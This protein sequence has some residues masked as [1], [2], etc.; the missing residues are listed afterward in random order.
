MRCARASFVRL[1]WEYNRGFF[2]SEGVSILVA[3]TVFQSEQDQPREAGAPQAYPNLM[4]FN[5]VDK[6]GHVAAWEQPQL[7]SD[8]IRAAFKSLRRRRHHD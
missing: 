8:E 6:G 4:Y 5:E 7:L 3:V 1:Y 2:N